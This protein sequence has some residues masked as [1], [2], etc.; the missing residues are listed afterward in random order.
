M[1]TITEQADHLRRNADGSY[2]LGDLVQ[3]VD[4]LDNVVVRKQG[5]GYVISAWRESM[6][7]WVQ[8][9]LPP[10]GDR[11]SAYTRALDLALD[12]ERLAGACDGH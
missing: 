10:H 7:V 5:G 2:H 4:S 3:L 8:H 9:P 6:G 1:T 12:S 11:R